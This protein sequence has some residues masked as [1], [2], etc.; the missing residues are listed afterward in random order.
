VRIS[1]TSNAV[2]KKLIPNVSGILI[3][4]AIMVLPQANG[5]L[6]TIVEIREP[7]NKIW[8]KS[9]L[10]L[11]HQ[12][13]HWTA[14]RLCYAHLKHTEKGSTSEEAASA[15]EKHLAH[16][17]DGPE[18]HLCWNPPI[19]SNSLRNQLGWHFSAKE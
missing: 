10:I 17:N 14:L 16:C 4:N 9:A 18:G 5:K 12:H 15:R 13:L 7:K 6:P 2:Q 8:D 3:Y 1:V 19:G 11:L